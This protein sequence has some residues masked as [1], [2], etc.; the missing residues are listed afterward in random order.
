MKARSMSLGVLI[1][2]SSLLAA[3]GGSDSGRDETPVVTPPTPTLSLAPAS[4]QLVAGSGVPAAIVVTNTS[5][6]A[7]AANVAAD[8]TGTALE[9][10]VTQDASGCQ[11]LAAGASCS[12]YFTPGNTAVSPV[13][14]AI[15]A[16]TGQPVAATIEVALP[17]AATLSLAGSPLQLQ[18]DRSAPTGGILTVTNTST[19]LTATNIVAQLSGTALDGIVVQDASSCISVAPGASCTITLTPDNSGTG[20]ASTPIAIQGDN[21]A[22]ITADISINAAPLLSISVSPSSL[23][24]IVDGSTK[25]LTVTN[26]SSSNADNITSHFN[27]TALAGLI[28]ESGNTCAA[29]LPPAASC[30][31]TFTPG[32][33]GVPQTT[34]TV[35]GPQ[36]T[37]ASVDFTIRDLHIGDSYQGGTILRLP[38]GSTPGLVGLSVLSSGGWAPNTSTLVGAAS[39]TD[40]LANSTLIANLY[41]T[42]PAADCLTYST[43]D[44]GVTYDEWYL[45]A[46]SELMDMI[47]NAAAQS[48]SGFGGPRW[49]STED[50]ATNAWFVLDSGSGA[51]SISGA[52]GSAITYVCAHTFD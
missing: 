10:N 34:A 31:L 33:T 21:T 16:D 11:V 7:A 36:T 5:A 6:E 52:K 18:G 4:L 26:T 44:G 45:P 40:G 51:N 13:Q 24:L 15:E 43:I 9:N 30:V 12:L 38:S 2:L 20:V 29:T 14:V 3:C 1:A 47:S 39:N 8:L 35:S 17:T 32:S 22:L 19:A 23:S 50:S 27:N 49:S 42:S 25:S 48:I 41:I 37:V 46:L 28:T